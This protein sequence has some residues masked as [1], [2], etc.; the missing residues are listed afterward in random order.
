MG[1]S[2]TRRHDPF[3]PQLRTSVVDYVRGDAEHLSD[4]RKHHG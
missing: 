4:D 3:V 2:M 1:L